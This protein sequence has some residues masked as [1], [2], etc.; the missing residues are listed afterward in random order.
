MKT[1]TFLALAAVLGLS[2]APVIAQ[3]APFTLT[4]EPSANIAQVPSTTASVP[5]KQVSLTTEQLEKLHALKN[6]YKTANSAKK[7]ELK[8]LKGQLRDALTAVTVDKGAALS[9]QSKINSLQADLA[10][11]RV[12][13]MADS[14]TIF[15]PEQ[16]E[17]IHRR[18]LMGGGKGFRGQ[19]GGGCGK[20]HHGGRGHHG[21]KGFH[22][23]RGPGGPGGSSSE[24][25]PGD[26]A[27]GGAPS[28]PST[29]GNT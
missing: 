8:L 21:G 24:Q 1:P 10:N 2:L 5:Q 23:K 27:E 6:Q 28:A 4:A 22:G 18:A 17:Q 16:R 9:L 25:G 3:E 26:T 15:T 11:S 14:S 7:A 20:G 13:L 19:R 12:S 29:S